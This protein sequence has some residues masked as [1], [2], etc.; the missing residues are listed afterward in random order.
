MEKG[1]NA[2]RNVIT[3]CK[4][5]QHVVIL[6]EIFVVDKNAIHG[7]RSRNFVYFSLKIVSGKTLEDQRSQL[8]TY[9]PDNMCYTIHATE[10][11][12]VEL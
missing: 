3:H 4:S 10:T 1:E 12:G 5:H 8:H 6:S 2:S 9:K 7:D 11:L